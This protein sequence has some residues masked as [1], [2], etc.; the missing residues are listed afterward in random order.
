VNQIGTAGP[1]HLTQQ[2][3]FPRMSRQVAQPGRAR[4]MIDLKPSNR[5][6]YRAI[7]PWNERDH[8]QIEAG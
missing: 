4:K 7:E 6:P 1:D 2:L 5:P 3:P 8:V